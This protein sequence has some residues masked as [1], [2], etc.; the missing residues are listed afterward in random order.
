MNEYSLSVIWQEAS[1]R[2]ETKIKMDFSKALFI[3]ILLIALF[4]IILPIQ[5][6][7]SRVYLPPHFAE[8]LFKNF[9]QKFNKSYNGP[10]EYQKRLNNFKVIFYNLFALN[11]SNLCQQFFDFSFQLFIFR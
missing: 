1:L 6:L 3:F 9:T 8:E 10:D 11:F 5:R 7:T 2:S 4:A